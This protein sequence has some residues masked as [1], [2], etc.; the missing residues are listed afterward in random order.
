LGWKREF[1]ADAQAPY[2]VRSSGS[3]PGFITYDDAE[4]TARKVEYVLGKRQ[5]GGVF[6]WAIGGHFGDYD[7]HSEDLLDAMFNTFKRYQS[8]PVKSEKSEAEH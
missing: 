1:D 4:S 7:G 2:L 6:T 3:E 8:L 5:L